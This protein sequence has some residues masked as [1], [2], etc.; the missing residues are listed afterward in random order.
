MFSNLSRQAIAFYLIWLIPPFI[1]RYA[2]LRQS[3]RHLYS[4]FLSSGV[5][6]CAVKTFSFLSN[7]KAEYI[8]L[9]LVGVM[10]WGIMSSSEKSKH[11]S[12]IAQIRR[13]PTCKK[14]IKIKLMEAS[15]VTNCPKCNAPLTLPKHNPSS[16]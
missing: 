14:K 2:I 4:L 11:V 13:C 6:Y 3:I 1:I 12:E 16:A 7:E 15:A 9:A 8:P 10:S 5:I